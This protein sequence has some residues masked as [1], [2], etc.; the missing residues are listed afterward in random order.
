MSPSTPDA[1]PVG[2]AAALKERLWSKTTST[3]PAGLA[4][5]HGTPGT[6]GSNGSNGEGT[7]VESRQQGCIGPGTRR[8]DAHRPAT[9]QGREGAGGEPQGTARHDDYL[10]GRAVLTS[11]SLLATRTRPH[12]GCATRK[13]GQLVL[14][15]GDIAQ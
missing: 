11:Y 7:E 1:L 15:L 9:R 12:P 14:L 2:S 8:K 13:K 6:N 3:V 10:A 4:G 5:I